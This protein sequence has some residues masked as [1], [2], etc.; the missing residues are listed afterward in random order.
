M[1]EMNE[2]GIVGQREPRAARPVDP[3][4]HEMVVHQRPGAG[5]I[6]GVEPRDPRPEQQLDD[7]D[8]D[9]GHRRTLQP[10]SEEHTSELQSL[11]RTSYAVF[12]LKQKKTPQTLQHNT[13][14]Q[15]TPTNYTNKTT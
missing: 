12:C 13:H 1:E 7:K 15:T 3:F 10:R 2:E 8:G 9:N 5:N 11:M 14:E 6:A 4:G